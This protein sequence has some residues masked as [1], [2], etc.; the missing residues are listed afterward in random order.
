MYIYTRR[1]HHAHHQ[2]VVCHTSRPGYIIII[3]V[4]LMGNKPFLCN[5]TRD[6]N[7]QVQTLSYYIVKLIA[8]DFHQRKK[9]PNVSAQ[10][11]ACFQS[12][13]FT[14]HAHSTCAVKLLRPGALLKYRLRSSSH[15]YKC[16][17]INYDWEAGLVLCFFLTQINFHVHIWSKTTSN[18][19]VVIMIMWLKIFHFR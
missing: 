13:N 12:Y 17:Y 2:A 10:R 15:I 5:W 8:D 9:M 1:A 7:Y 14:L 19:K 11:S 18:Q 4:L 3:T 6:S 16:K